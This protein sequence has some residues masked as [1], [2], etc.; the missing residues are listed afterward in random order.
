MALSCQNLA[1]L[2]RFYSWVTHVAI[3]FL[4]HHGHQFI[5]PKQKEMCAN[6]FFLFLPLLKLKHATRVEGFDSQDSDIKTPTDDKHNMSPYS[7]CG[8]AKCPE[9]AAVQFALK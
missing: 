9:D 4:P 1:A 2:R 8:V 5:R 3:S 6:V 7:S